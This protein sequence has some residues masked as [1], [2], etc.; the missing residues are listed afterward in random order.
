[1]NNTLRDHVLGGRPSDPLS[2]SGVL[3]RITFVGTVDDGNSADLNVRLL[4]SDLLDPRKGLTRME[5]FKLL[6]KLAAELAR[7][8]QLSSNL[9]YLQEAISYCLQAISIADIPA[10]WKSLPMRTWGHLELWK[11]CATGQAV[12]IDNAI[13]RYSQA[14]LVTAQSP[15]LP[16]CHDRAIREGEYPTAQDEIIGWRW[17][18]QCGDTKAL[19]VAIQGFNE[20]TGLKTDQQSDIH[21]PSILM[22]SGRALAARFRVMGYKSD[23]DNAIA[24]LSAAHKSYDK[25]HPH[26]PYCLSALA[27]A[28]LAQYEFSGNICDIDDAV[29]MHQGAVAMLDPLSQSHPEML[30]GLSAAYYAVHRSRGTLRTVYHLNRSLTLSRQALEQVPAADP[31]RLIFL[32]ELAHRL[33]YQYEETQ[34]NHYC[35]SAL[36]YIQ[37]ARALSETHPQ[38]APILQLNARIYVRSDKVDLKKACKTLQKASNLSRACIGERLESALLWADHARNLVDADRGHDEDVLAGHAPGSAGSHSYISASHAYE[39]ALDLLDG[40]LQ[41]YSAAAIQTQILLMRNDIKSLPSR[42][43]SHAIETGNLPCAVEIM[44][45]GRRYPWTSLEW[46]GTP[47]SHLQ[48]KDPGLAQEFR[49][50]NS[51]I[52]SLAVT[53]L[54]GNAL[55]LHAHVAPPDPT[56][57]IYKD[58]TMVQNDLLLERETILER[59]KSI[60][61]LS[62]FTTWKSFEVLHDAAKEGPVIMTNIDKGLAHAIIIDKNDTVPRQ[63]PLSQAGSDFVSKITS[64]LEKARDQGRQQERDC[65]P[66]SLKSQKGRDATVE[67]LQLL[68]ERICKPIV[69][70]LHKHGTKDH[71]RIWWCPS[72]ELVGIPLHAAGPYKASQSNLLDI[73]VS[74]YTD[75]LGTL[76]SSRNTYTQRSQRLSLLC[77]GQS[78]D[79][80]SVHDELKRIRAIFPHD[81]NIEVLDGKDATPQSVIRSMP[82]HSWVHFSCHG[83]LNVK[84]PFETYFYLSTQRLEIQDILKEKLPNAEMAMLAVCHGAAVGPGSPDGTISLATAMQF[85]GFK[86]VVGSLWAM[87]DADGPQLAEGFYKAMLSGGTENIDIR[88]ASRALH[89]VVKQMRDSKGDGRVPAWR[90]STFIHV[91]I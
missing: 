3:H 5:H 41:M 48:E 26:F 89:G 50:V 4:R 16:G 68:W 73:F 39:T 76:I 85:S 83:F 34:E 84:N 74:S 55:T 37:Q 43:A 35:D 20:A 12:Q 56:V 1:M 31:R 49:D 91:G 6:N 17:K 79:L 25:H 60:P 33:Y 14:L 18:E 58:R 22:N 62:T 54:D 19:D 82:Q 78:Q 42:A 36:A 59:I 8:T 15:N 30:S 71:S 9:G 61:D 24:A 51:R 87:S 88:K 11:F 81:I 57:G 46:S 38:L 90:W 70:D 69:D 10:H 75:S 21:R 28:T 45:R 27:S 2:A 77:I 29:S 23:L 72:G 32:G 63:V 53:S 64:D 65:I 47:L 44:E 67:S 52:E 80:N 40:Y 13:A 86:S 7:L 66:L